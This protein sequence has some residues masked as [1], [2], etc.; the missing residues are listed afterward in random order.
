MPEGG[1]G[2]TQYTNFTLGIHIILEVTWKGAGGGTTTLDGAGQV[3]LWNKA[4]LSANGTALSGQAMSCGTTLPD[5]VLGPLGNI[6][7]GGMNGKVSIAIP[8]ASWDAPSVPKFQE[9]GTLAGWAVGSAINMD[10][11][12]ALVGLTM[13]D[14][15]AAWPASFTGITGV[16]AEGDGSLGITGIPK[17]DGTNYVYPPTAIGLGGLQPVADKVYIA[18][19]TVIQLAG[20]TTTCEEQ[21]GTATAKFFDNHV[22]GC[23][24]FNGGE[25]TNTG[26]GNQTDF[27]DASRT[28]YVPTSGTFTSKKLADNATCADVRAAL[29]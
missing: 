20:K 2:C 13:P 24:V 3:H 10:P 21:A 19:R 5:I 22:I 16:D 1:G 15:M 17:K 7:A 9:T 4:T 6:A 18:S 11:T 28:I 23:H 29:P 27:I 14:P 12:V 25:C 26:N 8:F